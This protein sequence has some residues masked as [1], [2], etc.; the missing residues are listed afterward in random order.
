MKTVIITGCARG[1]GY[2]MIILF[3]HN[4]FNTVLCDINLEA[5]K[6]AKE[7]LLKE[8]GEGIVLAI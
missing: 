6:T 1:F 8:P 5:L 4:N 7:N 3:R 2:E